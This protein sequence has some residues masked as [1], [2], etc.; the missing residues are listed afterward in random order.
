MRDRCTRRRIAALVVLLSLV[1]SVLGT[2]PAR[3]LPPAEPTPLRPPRLFTDSWDIPTNGFSPLLRRACFHSERLG[4]DVAYLIYLPPDY[5]TAPQRRYPVMYFLV[6][7]SGDARKVGDLQDKL[8]QRIRD[9]RLPPMILVVPQGILAS[10]YTD[11]SDGQRPVETVLV[12]ELVPHVDR[13]YRTLGTREARAMEGHSMG[14]FGAAFLAFRYPRLFSAVSICSAPLAPRG[15][16]ARDCPSVLADVWGSEP[17]YFQ[18]RDPWNLAELHA[19]ELRRNLRVRLMVG[20][21]DRFRVCVE[22]MH[23]QLRKLGIAAGLRVLDNAGHD[24]WQ[25]VKQ[26][27]DDYWNFWRDAFIPT[28]PQPLVLVDQTVR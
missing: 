23:E 4:R 3:R 1:S 27:G 2:G 24:H 10:F 5:D 8:D 18:Q 15:F 28:S 13:Q 20:R 14:G 25:L 17:D 26:G 7:V 22:D 11:S 12:N 21:K 6:G 19:E 16:F 9:G